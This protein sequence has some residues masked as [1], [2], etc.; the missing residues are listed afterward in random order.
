[1]ST[2]Q[3][4]VIYSQCDLTAQC[5]THFHVAVCLFM[6]VRGCGLINLAL[7]LCLHAVL[8][9]ESLLLP[10]MCNIQHHINSCGEQDS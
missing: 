9:T 4:K 8:A 3:M 2:S 7:C 5:E 10:S 6:G 1:M